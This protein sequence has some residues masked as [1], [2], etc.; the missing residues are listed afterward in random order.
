MSIIRPAL[1]PLWRPTW[2][3]LA[4]ARLPWEAPGGGADASFIPRAPSLVLGSI[5]KGEWNETLQSGSPIDTW[6]P[7]NGAAPAWSATLTKRPAVGSTINSLAAP[8][9]DGSATDMTGGAKSTMISA[10][11]YWWL[12]VIKISAVVTSGANYFADEALISD[13]GQYIW[14]S[15]RNNAGAY[16]MGVGHSDGA[17]KQISASIALGTPFLFEWGYDGVNIMLR[18]GNAAQVSIAAGSVGSVAHVVH[19]GVDNSLLLHMNGLV[20]D[21][22]VCNAYPTA[23]QIAECRAYAARK[24]AVAA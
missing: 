23:A 24:W 12:G 1:G 9:F 22:L 10:A 11:A 21:L 18:V 4:S 5:L 7:A 13:V 3:P 14:A 2:G 8:A 20:G 17:A 15:F 6:T 16:T 19:L